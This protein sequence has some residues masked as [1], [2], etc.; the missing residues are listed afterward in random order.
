MILSYFLTCSLDKPAA[1]AYNFV[2]YGG[3]ILSIL[4]CQSTTDT[5]ANWLL[6]NAQ[7]LINYHHSS[8]FQFHSFTAGGFAICFHCLFKLPFLLFFLFFSTVMSYGIVCVCCFHFAH[9]YKTDIFH[10][11]IPSSHISPYSQKGIW[12]INTK[13]SPILPLNWVYSFA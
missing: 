4:C 2:G 12:K 3:F 8:V 10:L 6:E 13:I 9:M 5:V 11:I 1:V 7:Q